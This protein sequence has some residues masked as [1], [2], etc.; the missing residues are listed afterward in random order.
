MTVRQRLTDIA[1][2]ITGQAG[3]GDSTLNERYVTAVERIADCLCREVTITAGAGAGCLPINTA[4]RAAAVFPVAM[5]LTGTIYGTPAMRT[6][7]VRVSFPTGQWRLTVRINRLSGEYVPVSFTSY[8]DQSGFASQ[9]LADDNITYSI[10]INGA[11]WINLA[12]DGGV[13]WIESAAF[14]QRPTSA[15]TGSVLPLASGELGRVL[16]TTTTPKP[17]RPFFG[18]ADWQPDT[19]VSFLSL[20]TAVATDIQNIAEAL[21]DELDPTADFIATF[22]EIGQFG[23]VIQSATWEATWGDVVSGDTFAATFTNTLSYGSRVQLSVDANGGLSTA[24]HA[25]LA[26]VRLNL[27][28][29][30]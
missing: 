24:Q 21:A 1:L 11:G 18:P 8:T 17:A 30:Q 19:A 15:P 9:S 12:P 10:D 2:A 6:D 25:L 4:T 5:P 29:E 22:R 16:N 27:R 20:V 14:C 28:L 3:G 13:S 26:G 23:Q 7:Y